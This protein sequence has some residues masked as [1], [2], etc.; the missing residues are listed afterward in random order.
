MDDGDRP[1]EDDD[2]SLSFSFLPFPSPPALTHPALQSFFFSLSI[3]ICVKPCLEKVIVINFSRIAH[4]SSARRFPCLSSILCVCVCVSYLCTLIFYY[5]FQAM[6]RPPIIIFFSLLLLLSRP[7]LSIHSSCFFSWEAVVAPRPFIIPPHPLL[8]L[9]MISTGTFLS[10][11]FFFLHILVEYTPIPSL[12]RVVVPAPATNQATQ[13]LCFSRARGCTKSCAPACLATLLP[14]T[15]HSHSFA[16]AHTCR[17][18]A[19]VPSYPHPPPHPLTSN[20]THTH[21]TFFFRCW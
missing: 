4:R 10:G 3:F 19:L 16:I 18:S 7:C 15:E 12:L 6:L 1:D 9:P 20:H 2:A 21:T 5:F 14:G 8:F 11:S 17:A 13:P